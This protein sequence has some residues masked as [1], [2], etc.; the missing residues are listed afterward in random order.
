MLS[1]RSWYVSAV[2]YNEFVRIQ[3]GWRHGGPPIVNGTYGQHQTI[4][5][6]GEPLGF[7]PKDHSSM[8]HAALPTK[9]ASDGHQTNLPYLCRWL[10]IFKA[11]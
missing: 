8:G 6:F 4:M 10:Q 7:H 3:N 2:A 11:I 9:P 1:E 5:L